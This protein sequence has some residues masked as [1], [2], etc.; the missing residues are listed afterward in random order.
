MAAAGQSI[1]KGRLHHLSDE[2]RHFKFDN[3]LRP[4]LT[5][6]SGDVVVCRCRES[7]DG[8][9][10]T[11]STVETL[12]ELDWGRVHS[13]TGPV[14]VNGAEPGDVLAVEI[15][16]ITHE[17]WGWTCVYPGIGL[18]PDDFGDEFALRIW[19]VGRDGR[20]ELRP[21]LRIP[22][23]PFLGIMGVAL[24]APGE[25]STLP[26]RHVG[27]NID[28][29]HLC[30]GAAAYFPVE[31]AGA[32]FSV[33]DGHLAQGDGEV[34]GVAIEAPLTATLRLSVLKNREVTSVECDTTGP[35][36]SKYDGMGY[37]V[38]TGMGKDL[39]EGARAAVR[40]M[41]RYLERQYGLDK[42]D[43]YM[44]CSIAGDLKIAVPV[45]GSEHAGNVTFHMPRSIFGE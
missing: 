13:L 33:G 36:T 10:T 9:L 2:Q 11:R 44:L 45:L 24:G 20:V 26:P 23:E 14:A 3:S 4:A 29:R 35:T 30:K 27:G 16:D 21:G 17:G 31:V 25:H 6:E 37:H 39:Q 15:L 8:Q 42:T 32:L 34:C 40:S 5:I 28:I 19:N 18:L 43:A 38:T 41:I 22:T 12:R 7:C 1:N